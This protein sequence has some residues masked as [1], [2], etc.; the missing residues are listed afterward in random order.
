MIFSNT[1][2]N[3]L[4][5]NFNVDQDYYQSAMFPSFSEQ[6]NTQAPLP[7][8]FTIPMVKNLDESESTGSHFD[9]SAELSLNS[10]PNGRNTS[11]PTQSSIVETNYNHMVDHIIKISD[12]NGKSA[13]GE[14]KK[15][16]LSVSKK[17]LIRNRRKLRKTEIGL[18]NTEFEKN[19]NW[20]KKFTQ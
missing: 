5:F 15:G 14:S 2:N 4:T 10:S 17:L 20:S 18:L 19:P 9:T 16:R 7:F 1:E 13:Y 8:D 6:S 3:A 12:S 11:T